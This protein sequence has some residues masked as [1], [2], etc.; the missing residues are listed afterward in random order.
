MTDVLRGR[1]YFRVKL[2]KRFRI[3]ESYDV[4]VG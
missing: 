3:Y 2:K 4:A 1:K